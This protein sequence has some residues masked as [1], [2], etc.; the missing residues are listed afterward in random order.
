MGAQVSG[1]VV[2]PPTPGAPVPEGV[3]T[4]PDD[5]TAALAISLRRFSNAISAKLASIYEDTTYHR[6]RSTRHHETLVSTERRVSFWTVVESLVIS[7]VAFAQLLVVQRWFVEPQGGASPP[8][9]SASYGTH[10][11]SSSGSNF[12]FTSGQSYSERNRG[13]LV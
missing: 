4:V 10:K 6:V 1:S 13:G 9:P 12:G 11:S 2:K 7:A 3:A 8:R 5:S